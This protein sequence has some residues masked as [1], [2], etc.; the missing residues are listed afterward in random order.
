MKSHQKN[1][2][3]CSYVKSEF[4][5][6]HIQLSIYI[7][8]THVYRMS[9]YK[10]IE[11]IELRFVILKKCICKIGNYYPKATPSKR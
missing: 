10:H 11:M 1:T 8:G 4:I 5:S 9:S 3:Y 7:I 2:P 6:K